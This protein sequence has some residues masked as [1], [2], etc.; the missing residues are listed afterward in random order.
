MHAGER[1]G[2]I[3]PPSRAWRPTPALSNRARDIAAELLEQIWTIERGLARGVDGHRPKRV[4]VPIRGERRADE[5]A[6]RYTSQ[7]LIERQH[8]MCFGYLA[9]ERMIEHDELILAGKFRN[10]GEL[11]AVQRPRFPVDLNVRVRALVKAA[12]GQQRIDCSAVLPSHAS[13]E[14]L[15][16]S[17]PGSIVKAGRNL[18]RLAAHP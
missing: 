15:R 13:N 6:I 10:G 14:R 1:D 8:A 16:H 3:K 18:T 2:E 9:H 4:V 12:C 17:P 11:E 5:V 7:F